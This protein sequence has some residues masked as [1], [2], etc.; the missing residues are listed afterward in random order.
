MRVP[1][2]VEVS[3]VCT[4]HAHLG[5]GLAAR[6]LRAQLARLVP[7]AGVF[8]HVRDDNARAIGLY[9]RLGFRA[10]RRF[11]YAIVTRAS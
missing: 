6:L 11:R 8:L 1:G 2:L 3:G 5:R 10:R 9:E 4:D 7:D